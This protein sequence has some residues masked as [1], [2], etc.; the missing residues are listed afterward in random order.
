M[1]YLTSDAVKAQ[2][3]V[4]YVLH[5][6]GYEPV[7]RKG[8]DILYRTP[9]R[10]DSSPSLACYPSEDHGTVD[11][12]KDMAR[13]EG[14]DIFD[15]IFLLDTWDA[16]TFPDLVE[17]A[18]GLLSDLGEGDWVA[19][20]PLGSGGRFDLE[21][22]RASLERDA[23]ASDRGALLDWLRQREDST[24]LIHPSWLFGNF[25]VFASNGKIYAPYGDTG[26]YKYRDF[27]GK[28]MSPSGTRGMWDLF[29][30]EHLDTDPTRPVVLCEGEPDVWS[31]TH[32]TQ[33]Y[34]FLGLP[35][36]AG[37]RP[38][39]LQS[40]LAGRRVL[41]AF[42]GDNAGRD[43][44]TLWADALLTVDCQV[45][46]VPIPYGS[47]LSDLPDIPLMLSKTRTYRPRMPGVLTVN[48]AYFRASREG[49]PGQQISD[50][51]IT[52]KTVMI[53]ETG[54][55]SYVVDLNAAERVIHA[56]DLM[57]KKSLSNWAA[58]FG[59]VWNGSDTDVGVLANNLAVESLFLPVESSS[60][61]VG[62]Y[63]GQFVW[64]G[65][66]IGPRPMRY[67]PKGNESAPIDI[68]LPPVKPDWDELKAILSLGDPAIIHPIIAWCGAA[69][70]RSLF[71]QFPSLN[72]SGASGSGKTTLLESII[73]RI[74]G[75]GTLITLSST[76]NY[77]LQ[78][79]L[80]SGNAFPVVFDE[81]RT[82][83]RADVMLTLEQYVRNAYDNSGGLRSAG[84]ED[85]TVLSAPKPQAPIVL[86]GEQALS[87]TSII[88]RMI[89]VRLIR[90]KGRD[91]SYVDAKNRLTRMPPTLAHSYLHWIVYRSGQTVPD[92]WEADRAS[93]N[94]RVLRFGW[95]SLREWAETHN[96]Y[97][98][99]P[100][101]PDLTGIIEEHE[102]AAS[103]DD[104]TTA[105][106]W[107]LGDKHASENVWIEDDYLYVQVASFVDSVNRS[108]SLRLVGANTATTKRYLVDELGGIDGARRPH[109]DDFTGKRKRVVKVGAE[110]V[111]GNEVD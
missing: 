69:P 45:S 41:I 13:G 103:T 32:S 8:R 31:G 19:P 9:W 1:S 95:A 82:G 94:L 105:L 68:V 75:S 33:D 16:R 99:M 66:H 67:V 18:R 29:Y 83:S 24:S 97:D 6:A 72:V 81:F 57:S 48:D 5:A 35:T 10:A 26:L 20:E 12:W 23:L 84:G 40:R 106:E 55:L 89:L 46:I 4:T 65:G 56:V 30:G 91:Q 43:A 104:W 108:T 102:E 64:D 28:F 36:G 7:E 50:F 53:D 63:E 90:G 49:D 3:P 58:R 107:A 76:T 96:R 51:I 85:Y 42:D 21:E 78:R 70:F 2:L 61:K 62:L 71:D 109:P 38:E 79:A 39:K 52:P 73:S 44:A 37:T 93:H 98:V 80:D 74:T 111:F 100:E 47:D 14:G 59:H 34:V 88:D 22:A 27:D 110:R 60:S 15:M 11:R 92:I 101:A 54:G 87:E 77:G 17:V 25:G 86:A